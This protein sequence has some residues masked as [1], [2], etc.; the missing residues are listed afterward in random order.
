MIH[1]RTLFLA[2]GLTLVPSLVAQETPSTQ[3]PGTK[4]AERTPEQWIQDLGADSYRTR[5]AAEQALR[6]MGKKALDALKKAVE[7]STDHEVQ[8]RARRLVRQAEQGGAP[9]LT[10]RPPN[11]AWQQ[12]PQQPDQNG[13]AQ[14]RLQ[15]R[16]DEMFDRMEQEFGIDIPRSRFFH[17]DFFRDLQQQIPS[18]TSRSQG[19]SLQVG[20]DGKVRVEVKTQN[21]KGET[22]SKTYEADNMEQFRAQYPG[23]LRQN[24]LGMGLDLRFFGDDQGFARSFLMPRLNSQP[25]T[26]TPTPTQPLDFDVQ[27]VPPPAGSRLGITIRPSISDELREHLGLGDGVGLMVEAVQPDTIAAAIGLQRGDIVTKVAG[28]AIG[29]AADVQKALGAIEAGKDVEVTFLRK[30]VEKSA[31]APK[32]AGDSEPKKAQVLERR[33]PKQEGGTIR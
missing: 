6:A 14:D 15:R 4:S 10:R 27:A 5:V 23:V 11:D 21:E 20:A 9:G 33:T 26:T 16:V 7:T 13:S 19:M 24:G 29:S 17:D 1:L 28:H 31:T 32:P 2:A 22:E 12:A 3:D 30:G 25:W 8:W 18:G